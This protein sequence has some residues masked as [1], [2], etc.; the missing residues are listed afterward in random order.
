M[1]FSN[2]SLFSREINTKGLTEAL[3]HT[4]RLGF[5]AV[6]WIENATIETCRITDLSAA[7]AAKKEI[8]G[9]NLSVSCYSLLAN[10]LSEDID[11][12]M[13][14]I[15]KNIEYAAE[16]EAPFFHH[17]IIPGYEVREGAPS[18]DEALTR[19]A[20]N[21]ERIARYC[22]ENGMICLYEPQGIYFNGVK[23]LRGIFSE[24]KARGCKVGICGDTGN[25][26]YVDTPPIEIYESFA[27]DIKHIHVKDYAYTTVPVS[28][29]QVSTSGKYIKD[30][31][32][33]DGSADFRRCFDFV[34]G[35]DGDVS[36]EMN[37]DD[38][39]ME[40]N[41]AFIRE[42]FNSYK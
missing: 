22:N 17:T 38:V 26:L 25:S 9:R 14:R 24:M 7:R 36:F 1:K 30:V 18:Y 21:A 15:F 32:L 39:Q 37:C 31:A 16:L 19:V 29:K 6:E 11:A 33:G 13:K 34:K 40:K 35:Y 10:L 2:Y 8:F 12:Q 42:I 27:E 23:G 5:D 20:D 4:L 28:E 41:Q 3:E